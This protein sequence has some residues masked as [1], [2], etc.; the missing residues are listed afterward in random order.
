M[1]SWPK[2][3]AFLATRCSALRVSTCA[4]SVVAIHHLRCCV[5]CLGMGDS[6]D[7]NKAKVE[8]WGI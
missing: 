3:M 2:V 7:E 4:S 1:D 5:Q 6:W 8:C